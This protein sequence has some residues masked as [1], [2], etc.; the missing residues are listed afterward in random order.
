MNKPNKSLFEKIL[1]QILL[2]DLEGIYIT[3]L[4]KLLYFLEFNYLERN[5]E[6]LLGEEF[7]KNH[8]GPTSIN[9]KKFLDIL[10][11]KGLVTTKGTKYVSAKEKNYDFEEKI[12]FELNILKKEYL[13]LTTKEISDKSHKDSPFIASENKKL[14]NKPIVFFRTKEFSVFG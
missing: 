10:I 11:Q 9:L 5:E 4:H 8:Y 1:H 6:N 14:I 2:F 12:K 3:K 13:S 7:L